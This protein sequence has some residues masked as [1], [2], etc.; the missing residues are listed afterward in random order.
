M[1]N[2]EKAD[3]LKAWLKAKKAEDTAKNKRYAIEEQINSLY[4]DFDG[5]SKTFKEEDLGFS[6]NVKKNIRFT[7]DQDA[8]ASVRADIPEELRP[9]KI[10]FEVDEKGFKFLKESKE[11]QE[12]YRKVSDCVTIKEN[13]ST[14]KVEKI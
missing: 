10:K 12:T 4:P 8:W 14:I 2:M 9:E 5:N 7:F 11:Y 1:E 3:L 13:K 6:V